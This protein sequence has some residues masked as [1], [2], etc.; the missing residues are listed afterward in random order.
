MVGKYRNTEYILAMLDYI[1]SYIVDFC[2]TFMCKYFTHTKN[3]Q[4][5]KKSNDYSPIYLKQ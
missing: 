3:A 2:Y 5:K 1:K 4:L